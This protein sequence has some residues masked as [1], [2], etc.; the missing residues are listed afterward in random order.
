[1][2]THKRNDSWARWSGTTADV[3]AIA[4]IAHKA[5][6]EPREAHAFSISAS[7]P[8]LED[9]FGSPGEFQDGSERLDLSEFDALRIF[10]HGSHDLGR[11]M[12]F[13]D[14][15]HPAAFLNVEGD[16]RNW[17]EGTFGSLR[18]AIDRGAK[19]PKN[20]SP[21]G[22]I[23]FVA[24][25]VLGVL[26]LVDTLI[27]SHV[28]SIVVSVAAV[29]VALLMLLSG[30]IWAGVFLRTLDLVPAGADTRSRRFAVE[31]RKAIGLLGTLILGAILYA[32]AARLISK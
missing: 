28:W 23:F 8:S 31:T 11:V 4:R 19:W 18:D 26:A 24:L 22:L 6:G 5:I 9:E 21:L 20:V 30:A 12:V 14:R 7:N 15:G 27:D 32:L 16:D 1:M 17:V 29:M 25:P 3:V 10:G 2:A 13:F